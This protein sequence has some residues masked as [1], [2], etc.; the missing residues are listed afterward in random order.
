MSIEKDA[1]NQVVGRYDLTIF[2]RAGH[3][4]ILAECKSPE[5][6]MSVDHWL[7]LQRY[8]T[9]LKAPYIFWTNGVQSWIFDV[10]KNEF[11]R[12]MDAV[13]SQSL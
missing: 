11:L 13:L 8:N 6:A 7:Q 1:S 12:T 10:K 2:D 4:M 9:V 3:P 5:I